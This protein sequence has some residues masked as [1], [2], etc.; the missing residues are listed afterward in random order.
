MMNQNPP[1]H[2][3]IAQLIREANHSRRGHR[4]HPALLSQAAY[5]IQLLIEERD[6][7]RRKCCMTEARASHADDSVVVENAI[8][9]AEKEGWDCFGKNQ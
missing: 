3:L 6:D 1:I 8:N 4:T 9:V 5:A 7:A 2:N